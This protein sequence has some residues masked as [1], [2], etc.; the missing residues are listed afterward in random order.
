MGGFVFHIGDYSIM[1]K[2]PAYEE[3]G[4]FLGGRGARTGVHISNII[5]T[6]VRDNPKQFLGR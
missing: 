2:K 3:T 6:S 5:L 1:K 4:S